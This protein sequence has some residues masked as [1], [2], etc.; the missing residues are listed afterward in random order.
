VCV[1]VNE[2]KETAETYLLNHYMN[3]KQNYVLIKISDLLT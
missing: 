1:F 2:R 3:L